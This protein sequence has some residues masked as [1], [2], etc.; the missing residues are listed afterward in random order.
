LRLLGLAWH[1]P[2]M[3]SDGK[4]DIQ[5]LLTD[6]SVPLADLTRQDDELTAVATQLSHELADLAC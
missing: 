6:L 3:D 4:R 1:H 5:R 2:A